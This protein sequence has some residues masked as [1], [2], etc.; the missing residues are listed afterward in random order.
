MKVRVLVAVCYRKRR[1][2]ISVAR[3]HGTCPA[4]SRRLFHPDEDITGEKVPGVFISSSPGTSKRPRL[5]FGV[6]P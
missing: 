5:F 2:E 4:A 6:A 3:G 1:C